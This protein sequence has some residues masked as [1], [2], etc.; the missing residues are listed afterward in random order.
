MYFGKR[1]GPGIQGVNTPSTG[2]KS[3][4]RDGPIT[5][6][7]NNNNPLLSETA[8]QVTSGGNAGPV[9]V[10]HGLS[11]TEFLEIIALIAVE[12][13]ASVPQYSNLFPTPY[14]RVLAVLTIWGVADLKRLE[15]V[16]LIR[17]D[18][19]Y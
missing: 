12:G 14:S 4:T 16:R 2:N 1:P 6:T 3:P 17:T 10:V 18:E 11:F 5:T 7:T 19:A 13:L 15:E 9:P 8:Q